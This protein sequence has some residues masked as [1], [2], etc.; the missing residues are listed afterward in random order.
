M[1]TGETFRTLSFLPLTFDIIGIWGP[2]GVFM[3]ETPYFLGCMALP[4]FGVAL[5]LPIAGPKPGTFSWLV[6]M[7]MGLAPWF[8]W[9]V[10]E[11]LMFELLTTFMW[12]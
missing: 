10:E 7:T 8:T 12:L 1:L 4:W 2:V 11:S 5:A 6:L 9:P 3:G